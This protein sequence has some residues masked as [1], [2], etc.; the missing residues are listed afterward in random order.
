MSCLIGGSI[1]SLFLYGVARPFVLGFAWAAAHGGRWQG[2]ALL[3]VTIAV[4]VG[5]CALLI[6]GAR[7]LLSRP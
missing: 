3:A 7:R 6:W 1:A 5:A 2:Y 4:T